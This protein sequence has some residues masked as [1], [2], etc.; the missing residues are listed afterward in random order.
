[1]QKKEERRQEF[2]KKRIR[3]KFKIDLRINIDK[4]HMVQMV[5]R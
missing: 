2:R 5:M 4:K 1:M 3:K